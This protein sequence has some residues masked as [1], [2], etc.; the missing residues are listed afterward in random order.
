MCIHPSQIAPANEVFTPSSEELAAARRVVE[1]F[2]RAEAEGS[3]SIQLDGRFIDYPIVEKARR[4]LELMARIEAAGG[5]PS[6]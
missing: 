6:A 4:S 5:E 1:A 3:A 2:E